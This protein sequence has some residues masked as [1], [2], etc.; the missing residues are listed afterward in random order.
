MTNKTKL[1]EML[2]K[3]NPFTP[4][5]Q[6]VTPVNLYAPVVKAPKQVSTLA[7]KH[8]DTKQVKLQSTKALKQKST[9]ALKHYSTKALKHFSSYLTEQSLKA[10]KKEA[11]ET[12]RKDYEVIQEAVNVF[13][14]YK[15]KQ[16]P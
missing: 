1:A 3:R 14:Y 7:L 9:K 8:Q 4:Q 5:R 15:N 16:K 13:F 2:K 12:D 6:A 10:I 11:I